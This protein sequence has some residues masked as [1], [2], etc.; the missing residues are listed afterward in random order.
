MFRVMGTSKAVYARLCGSKS[1]FHFLFARPCHTHPFGERKWTK[2]KGASNK[3]HFS[4]ETRYP[5]LIGRLPTGFKCAALFLD[6]SPPYSTWIFNDD[7]LKW[8][9]AILLGRW[10]K[11]SKNDQTWS[12]YPRSKIAYLASSILEQFRASY[13]EFSP[14]KRRTWSKR[15]TFYSGAFLE[16]S[17]DRKAFDFDKLG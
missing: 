4:L 11:K 9:M 10:M 16:I 7:L 17:F 8:I 15:H 3:A 1:S 14:C 12:F 5:A 6:V 2:R 13:F